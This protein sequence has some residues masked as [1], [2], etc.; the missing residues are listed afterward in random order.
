[1][2]YIRYSM[3]YVNYLYNLYNKGTQSMNMLEII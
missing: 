3:R 1:M 2:A